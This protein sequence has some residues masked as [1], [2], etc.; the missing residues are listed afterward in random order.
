MSLQ[1]QRSYFMTGY[2]GLLIEMREEL[3][4]KIHLFHNQARQYSS[5]DPT[6]CLNK[7]RIIGE[8]I[9]GQVL[10]ESKDIKQKKMPFDHL[11][12]QT[13]NEV[14]VL[15][16]AHARVIQAYGN[17][18]SHYQGGEEPTEA[19]I[20]SC[21]AATAELISWFDPNHKKVD[22]EPIEVEV[23][24]VIDE[25]EKTTPSRTIRK[26]MHDMVRE[27]DLEKG[28]IIS[29]REIKSWF[30]KQQTD[31]K[32]S[33]ITTHVQMM[34]TNGETRLFHDLSADGSDELFFRVKKGQYRLYNKE[35]D[36]APIS[37]IEQFSGWE[38]KLLI[39]NTSRSFDLVKDTAIYLSPNRSGN[40]KLA[41]SKYIGLYNKKGVRA[42]AEIAGKVTFRTE[43]S[44]GY[45]WWKNTDIS[46]EEILNLARNR[47]F[48]YPRD[49]WDEPYPVQAIVMKNVKIINFEN[50][51][52]KNFQRNNRVFSSHDSNSLDELIERIDGNSW[53]NW[54]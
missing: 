38:D 16:S 22:P 8:M 47:V 42:V 54:I 19:A 4:E 6:S 36:P 31:H 34:T 46:N 53:S 52:G 48:N 15:V 33:S 24:E 43:K 27:K 11:I 21:L 28:D 39:V 23:E 9:L 40:Y 5:F 1:N 2:L 12:A 41:R 25:V 10:F 30:E 20:I 17:F 18:G 50:D 26:M 14:P 7:C 3:T 37:E 35:I 32:E 29:L 45:V 49:D 51:T 44:G 13:M